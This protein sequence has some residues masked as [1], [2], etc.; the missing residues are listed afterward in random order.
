MKKNCLIKYNDQICHKTA[1]WKF[2]QTFLTHQN[3]AL[4]HMK[5]LFTRFLQNQKII[6]LSKRYLAAKR[7]DEIVS[8]IFNYLYIGFIV[9][10]KAHFRSVNYW[11]I[12]NI[13]ITGLDMVSVSSFCFVYLSTHFTS[14]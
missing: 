6:S 13:T 3:L 7:R 9:Q 14:V 4:F 5:Y 10:K 1:I 8:I 11:Q 12:L 2:C